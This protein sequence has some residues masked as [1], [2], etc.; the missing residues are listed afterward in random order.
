MPVFRTAC[1]LAGGLAPP[2]LFA[3]QNRYKVKTNMAGLDGPELA[4]LYA[5]GAAG[6]LKKPLRTIV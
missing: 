3:G 1:A 2:W 4:A 5:S 6:W